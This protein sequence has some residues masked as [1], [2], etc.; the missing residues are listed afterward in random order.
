MAVTSTVY[1]LFKKGQLNGA[2][3]VDFDTDTIKLMLCTST[4]SPNIDTHE[5]KT[6]VTN[7][8]AAGGGYSS[9]GQALTTKVVNLDTASDFAYLKADNVTWT[10]ATF[11]ARYGVLYKDTGSGATSPLI[12]VIDFGSDQ[13]PSGSDFTVQW[14]SDGNGGVL[15]FA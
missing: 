11:T 15:K 6:D 5:F 2:H 14:A 1:N 10:T 7:E 8:V 9:G 4:Y 12:L 3:F 13:S